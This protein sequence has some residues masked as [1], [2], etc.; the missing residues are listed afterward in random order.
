MKV[1][2]IEDY[3]SIQ[4]IYEEGFKTAGHDLEVVADGDEALKSL[5]K[6]DYDLVLLDLLLPNVDGMELLRKLEAADR[7]LD[8]IVVLS[9][10]DKPELI[11]ECK[12][13]GVRDF[14][15]KVEYT[16]KELIEVLEK[17]LADR[18]ESGNNA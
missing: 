15:V 9:D 6:N 12:Q 1:L 2:L 11:E 10:F 7:S 3:P 14:L 17:M 4:T 18:S 13:L 5:K 8:N 16:P